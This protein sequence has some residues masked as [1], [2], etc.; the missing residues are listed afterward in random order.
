VSSRWTLWAMPDRKT[1]TGVT[2]DAFQCLRSMSESS[3]GSRFEPPDSNTG[4]VT[5]DTPVGRV[6]LAFSFEAD[7]NELT[8]SVQ[9]KPLLV[10]EFMIWDGIEGMLQRAQRG[11]EA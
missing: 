4:T 2:M 7:R 5:T 3:Y 9:Q 6:V 1:W 11:A 10:T 8:Y